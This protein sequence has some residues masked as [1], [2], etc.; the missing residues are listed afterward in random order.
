M[1]LHSGGERVRFIAVLK[2]GELQQCADPRTLNTRPANTFVAGFIGSPPVNL[3]AATVSAEG[4]RLE[5]AGA[6]LAMGE[7]QRA[8]VAARRG[9]P[10]SMAVRPEDLV[11]HAGSDGIAARVELVEPLGNETLVH[12]S[13]AVGALVSRVHAGPVPALGANAMLTARADG[14]LLFDAVSGAALLEPGLA[15][16][17][18]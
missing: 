10:V 9:A 11:L 14:I 4:G 13:S 12:W 5:V 6:A 18:G 2:A 1:A 17:A 7:Q 8:A 3:F 15:S 16:T